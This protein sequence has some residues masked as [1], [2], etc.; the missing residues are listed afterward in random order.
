MLPCRTGAC[1]QATTPLQALYE[2]FRI[3]KQTGQ[4]GHSERAWSVPRTVTEM[5]Q[6]RHLFEQGRV[7]LPCLEMPCNIV[8]GEASP[9]QVQLVTE[10]GGESLM[11]A[12]VERRITLRLVCFEGT[13]GCEGALSGFSGALIVWLVLTPTPAP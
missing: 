11:R 9:H 2:R 3:L 5:Q 7:E 6:A 10:I 12:I 1:S 13:E 4:L 8:G